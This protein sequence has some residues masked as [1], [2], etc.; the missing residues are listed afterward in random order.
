[1]DAARP[2]SDSSDLM[3]AL[4]VLPAV[5]DKCMNHREQ[6]RMKRIYQRHPY[7][8]EKREAWRL[9]G[10]HLE[11]LTQQDSRHEHTSRHA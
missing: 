7:T 5:I 9:L 4:G 8:A 10:E 2:T 3:Q 1:M 11:Q 6:N